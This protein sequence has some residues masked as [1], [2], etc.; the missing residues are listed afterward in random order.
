MK[1]FGVLASEIALSQAMKGKSVI[2]AA[3]EGCRVG[4]YEIAGDA[5]LPTRVAI[6]E[7]L[8]ENGVDINLCLLPK[9]ITE[10]G[11]VCVDKEGKDREFKGDSVVVC[12][13]F[14]PD[15][16]LTQGLMG[17]IPEVRPIGDCVEARIISDAIHEGW[18]AGNQV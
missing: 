7:L 17:K 10:N 1:G 12:R 4:E 9:E 18:L 5:A 13:G 14:L 11:V 2:M 8:K 3:P 6:L 15:K 16:R